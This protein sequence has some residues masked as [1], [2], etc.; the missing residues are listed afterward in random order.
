MVL[1]FSSLQYNSNNTLSQPAFCLH[2]AIQLNVNFRFGKGPHRVKFTIGFID[3]NGVEEPRNF[4][5]EL[6]SID[7][8]PH[9]IHFFLDMV[10]AKVWDN[11]VFLH[12]EQVEHV[13]QVAPI[14]FDTQKEVQNGFRLH[15]GL[16][17]PEYSDE[18][19]HT[20]YTIGFAGQGPAFYI[21][22]MDN[23]RAHG[24]GGQPNH[25][26]SN[27]GDPCFGRVVDGVEVIDDLIKYG[28]QQNQMEEG[29]HPWADD[30]HTWTHL[31]SV[32]MVL[33]EKEAKTSRN[34]RK[35]KG[36]N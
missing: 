15:R 11:T 33:D 20:K 6:G 21:N 1:R 31:I 27:D 13:V 7:T 17:F 23:S 25:I 2:F 34:R 12:H 4:V 9:S 3:K 24:P 30:K 22:T 10:A 5:V 18:Y 14:D 36:I 8:M 16:G 35:Q 29:H 28:M 32:E 26:M 19:Q